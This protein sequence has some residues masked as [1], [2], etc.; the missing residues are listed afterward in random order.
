MA[1]AALILEKSAVSPASD[2]RMGI[3]FVMDKGWHIYWKNPGD[4]GEPTEFSG[5]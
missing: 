3:K 4:S 1:T 2:V 5:I